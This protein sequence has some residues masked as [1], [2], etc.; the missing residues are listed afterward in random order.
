MRL[1]SVTF[2]SGDGET[3]APEHLA[4]PDCHGP[5]PVVLIRRGVAGRDDGYTE[6]ARRLAEWG[7]VALLHGSK[8]RG[9]DP[10]DGPVYADRQAGSGQEG[11][12]DGDPPTAPDP[13]KRRR[14]S[15]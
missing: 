3:G 14:A 4:G 15:Q 8:V 7:C 12:P 2:T 10:T 11:R 1:E 6:I 13:A 5:H 9:A